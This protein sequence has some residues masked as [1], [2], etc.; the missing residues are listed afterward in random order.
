M[1]VITENVL[2]V[3]HEVLSWTSQLQDMNKKRSY[4]MFANKVTYLDIEV[5]L[6]EN[7]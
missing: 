2:K 6:K 3:A 7:V 4:K 5:Y 1:L